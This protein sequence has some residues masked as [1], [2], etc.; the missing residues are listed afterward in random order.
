VRDAHGT[1]HGGN[2]HCDRGG[3]HFVGS[4]NRRSVREIPCRQIRTLD[5]KS[6]GALVGG[7]T[8]GIRQLRAVVDQGFASEVIL[9]DF[10]FRA[11]FEA[12]IALGVS[13][14]E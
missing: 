14:E 13:K 12:Y 6:A 7:A 10:V 8:A 4:G 2:D 3:V 1:R 5:A 9:G 11:K